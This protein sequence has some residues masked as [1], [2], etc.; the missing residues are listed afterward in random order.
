MRKINTLVL[1][2]I[3]FGI[4]S[5]K[6]QIE[7]GNSSFNSEN[8]LKVFGDDLDIEFNILKKEVENKEKKLKNNIEKYEKYKT[9]TYD[10]LE[11]LSSLDSFLLVSDSN[12]FFADGRQTE[13]AEAFILETNKYLLSISPILDNDYISLCVNKLIGLNDVQNDQGIYFRYLDYYYNGATQN[14]FYYLIKKRKKNVLFIQNEI[15][16]SFLLKDYEEK[17]DI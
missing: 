12:L 13:V 9:H 6:N 1:L 17:L 8:M 3:L 10:Y 15:L 4:I 11:Y 7:Q 16:T 14:T 2:T 5:C